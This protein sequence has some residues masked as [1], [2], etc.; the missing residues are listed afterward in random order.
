MYKILSTSSFIKKKNN[1]FYLH[2]FQSLYTIYLLIGRSISVYLLSF[3]ILNLD[4]IYIIYI[5]K[6]IK[7]NNIK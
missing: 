1:H 5:K 7:I 2:I 4:I 6:K 3:I